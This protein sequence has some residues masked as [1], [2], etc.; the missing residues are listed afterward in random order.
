MITSGRAVNGK[1]R[2]QQTVGVRGVEW[3][4][5]SEEE[6]RQKLNEMGRTCMYKEWATTDCRNERGKQKRETKAE[7]ERH[8][9]TRELMV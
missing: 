4:R 7:M 5:T 9:E 1:C 8:L 2:H 3:E 6:N